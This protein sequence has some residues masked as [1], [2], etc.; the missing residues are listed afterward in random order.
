[1]VVHLESQ[2]HADNILQAL[3]DSEL[4]A[5]IKITD[6]EKNIQCPECGI[7]YFSKRTMMRHYREK[8]EGVKYPCNQFEYQATQR[9][10]L[11]IHI[12]AKHEGVKYPCNQC[13]YQATRQGDLQRH[14]QSVHEAIKYPCNQCDYQATRENY[15]QRHIQSKHIR[16]I[17]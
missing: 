10:N 11:Q 16:Y 9:S 6:A 8:H 7:K 3:T 13:Y 4:D 14:I 15:L 1:M 17:K 12:L 2:H 5:R